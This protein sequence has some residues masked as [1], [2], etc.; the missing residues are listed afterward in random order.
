MR[1]ERRDVHCYFAREQRLSF[2]L[3]PFKIHLTKMLRA[4]LTKKRGIFIV[5]ILVQ[6]TPNVKTDSML[7]KL[8]F[9]F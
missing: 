8:D 2:R 3:R 5:F 7:K 1:N 4:V 9:L 6:F